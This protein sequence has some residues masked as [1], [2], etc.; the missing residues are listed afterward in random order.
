MLSFLSPP[1]AEIN[2]PILT[3]YCSHFSYIMQEK[4]RLRKKAQL[5][6]QENQALLSELKQKQK[7]AES[8]PSSNPALIPDLNA[9]PSAANKGP[10]ASTSKP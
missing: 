7:L 4:E 3:F 10:G 9:T 1:T 5:L 2:S 8:S 6:N